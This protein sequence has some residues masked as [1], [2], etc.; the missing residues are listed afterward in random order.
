M[1]K[2]QAEESL[3][4]LE[5]G[6][7]GEGSVRRKPTPSHSSPLTAQGPTLSFKETLVSGHLFQ[8]PQVSKDLNLEAG[9]EAFLKRRNAFDPRPG[10]ATWVPSFQIPERLTAVE[11]GP[12]QGQLYAPVALTFKQDPVRL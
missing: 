12:G 4:R 10:S 6:G 2:L 1:Q 7:V 11:Q 3:Q 5:A 8:G 9:K